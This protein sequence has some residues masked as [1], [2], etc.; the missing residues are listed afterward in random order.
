MDMLRT[1]LPIY[2]IAAKLQKLRSRSELMKRS[3]PYDP[4]IQAFHEVLGAIQR[5]GRDHG[6]THTADLARRA[7]D[8]PEP[9]SYGDMLAALDHLNDSLNSELEEEA[10]F[11]I[12]RDRKEFFEQGELFG[13]EVATAFPSCTRDIQRAG[14]CY[15]LAQ[16][17]ACVHHLMLVL[18]RGLNALAV[19]LSVACQRTNWQPVIDEIG[20]VLKSLPRGAERDF[21]LE[22]N[23]QFGF[24][25]DAYRNHSQHAHDE[26]YDMPKA[27]SILNHVC[28]FMQKLAK[29]GLTE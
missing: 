2:Q 26:P 18:E 16:E 27:Q 7:N 12:P 13:P 22:V 20:K 23:A 28:E 19:K 10:I 29:G 21:Y 14:S 25:K 3:A 4:D 24:L 17:D 9:E 5:D 15:A 6:L 1:Y 8:R 11:C